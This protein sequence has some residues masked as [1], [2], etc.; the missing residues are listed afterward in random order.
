MSMYFREGRLEAMGMEENE[1]G[2]TIPKR[3]PSPQK[4]KAWVAAKVVHEF[5]QD[6]IGKMLADAMGLD[7]R[8]IKIVFD[9][10]PITDGYDRPTGGYI[11]TVKV[12]HD[13]SWKPPVIV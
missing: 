1:G 5:T 11:T 10:C 6:E 7:V 2:E 8:S 12:T 3:N 9:V 4:E 13:R